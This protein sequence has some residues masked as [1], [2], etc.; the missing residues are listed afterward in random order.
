MKCIYS[1]VAAMLAILAGPPTTAGTSSFPVHVS[2]SSLPAQTKI[3]VSSFTMSA[4]LA[5][6]AVTLPSGVVNTFYTTTLTATGGTAPFTWSYTG[7]LPA[8]L[9]LNSSTGVISG[10]PTTAGTWS[11]TVKVTDSTTPTALTA[12]QGLSITINW[13]AQALSITTTSL[14]DGTAGAAYS[15]SVNATGGTGVYTWSIVS[16][17]TFPTCL[18]LSSTTGFISGSPVNTCLGSF[19][20]TVQVEDSASNTATQGLS[21]NINPGSPTFCESGNES[22]LNGHYA[23]DLSGYNSNGFNAV[24]GSMIADGAGHITGGEVDMNGI[25][26]SSSTNSPISASPASSYTVGSD[27]RGCATIATTSGATFT[28]RFELG[29]ISSGTATQGRIIEFDPATSSAFIASGQILRQTT[30]NFSGGLSG[31]YAFEQSGAGSHNRVVA[32]GVLSASSGSFSNGEVDMNVAGSLSHTTGI[33]GTYASADSNGR[34]TFTTTVPSASTSHGAGYMVSSSQFLFLTTDA[35]T[36]YGVLPGQMQ[37]QSGTFSNSSLSGNM[38]FYM[39]GLGPVG[40]F[41]I[42]DIGLLSANGTGS[43]TRT[44]YSGTL[45]TSLTCTY[46]IAS[47]GRTTITSS[48]QPPVFYLTAANTAFMLDTSVDVEIGQVLAQTVPGSG[49]TTASMAGTFFGGTTEIVNQ[50]AEAEGE[51]ATVSGSGSPNVSEI[52]DT[53]STAYQQADQVGTVALTVASTGT[54]APSAYPTYVI[55]IAIDTTHFLVVNSGSSYSTIGV[56]GPSTADTVAVSVSSPTTAQTV[57][58]NGGFFGITLNVTGTSGTA[59]TWTFN[60]LPSGSG[61]GTISG[62][63][64]SFTYAAPPRVPS[65]A[66]FSITATSDADLTKSAS[67]SVTISAGVGTQPLS[68]TTTSLPSSTGGAAYVQNVQTSGGTLPIIWSVTSGSLPP[69]LVLQGTPNGVGT[70]TG[71]PKASGTYTF[72]VAASDASIPTQY[73]SQQF[74]IVIN[75]VPLS[76]TTR[77]L[78][79]GTQG[80]AYSALVAVSGGTTPYTWSVTGGALPGWATLNAS[81]GAITGTPSSTATSNFTVTVTDSTLPTHQTVQQSLS[82]TISEFAPTCSGAPAGHESMLNGQ[83]AVLLQGF[84]LAFAASFHADGAGHVTGGDFDI[85]TG[86]ATDGTINASSYTVGPDPTGSGNLGCVA[87]PLSNGSTTIFRFSLGGLSSGV[88]SKARIIEFDDV[89]GEGRRGSGVLL[90]QDT[91]SFSLSHLQPHY[92]FGL[93]GWGSDGGHYASAGSF[94]VDTSGNISSGFEDFNSAG[95]APG[96]LTG[97][98]GTFNAISTT[99][100][101]ATMSLSIGGITTDQIIYMVNA[102]E[103]FIIGTDPVSSVPI[104]SGRAIVTASSFS[105]SSVS[106]NYIIHTTGLEPNCPALL[107]G[108]IFYYV[109]CNSTA[110]SLVNLDPASGTLSGTSY[111]YSMSPAIFEPSSFSGVSYAVDATSGRTTAGLGWTGAGVFYIATPTATTEPIS[112]FYVSTPDSRAHFGFVEYQPSA[113]YSTS[114]MAGNY[115]YGT[116]DSGDSAFPNEIG[117]VGVSSGGAVTG[118]E[119][120]SGDGGLGTS[121]PASTI[122]MGSNG[123][124]SRTFSDGCGGIVAITNGTRLFVMRDAGCY[125][126][127]S[128]IFLPAMINVYEFQP[129]PLV[130][131]SAPSLGFGNQ[132]L[133]TTSAPLTETVTNNGTTNL[134]IST[135]TIGGTNASDFA[136]STDICTSATVLPNSTCTVSV[137]FTPSAAGSRSA[138]LTFTDNAGDSPQMV[139]LSGTGA[140][141]VAGL[142]PFG[143]TF[144]SQ[145]VGIT[146]GLQ[147]V[148]LSNTGSAALT[149]TSITTGSDFAQTNNCAGSVAASGSCTINVT[150]TPTVPGPRKGMVTIN[151]NAAGSPHIVIVTGVGM[152]AGLAPSSL[153]F[154]SQ[155][156]GTSSSLQ[157]VTLS[158][159]G[160]GVMHIWQMAITGANASDFAKTTTCGSTLAAGTKCTISVTFTPSA[161]GTRSASLLVS[162]DGGGGPQAVALSGTGQ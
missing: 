136:K 85:N 148:T 77:A 42:V 53:A 18:S 51:M 95:T 91:T 119:Y 129:V 83:Y 21:I 130:G 81:S 147:P 142:S 97:G 80:T 1:C 54:I 45:Q 101:R 162:N 71:M 57:A 93:D 117:V 82:I 64:P 128:P 27:N 114:G 65:P 121:S 3:Q 160:S 89:T 115:F 141:P 78:P 16:G 111:Y 112:G 29:A 99:T 86:T 133:S 90:L 137:T 31:S 88:F 19:S 30:A 122:S 134:T 116:E 40:G 145:N 140:A 46:S 9:S 14:Q 120:D 150:F 41:A 105:Q 24:V 158:N 35:S 20:F 132:P 74:T 124:G 66:T 153:T 123:V 103:T 125:S 58:A 28:T 104:F 15:V 52:K 2:D 152:A 34:F 144:G 73:A 11:F 159:A 32:V 98:T 43:F 109:S 33:T 6:P 49:F 36:T 37:Q 155:N 44:D 26:A 138:S 161:G 146:S 157:M 62:S 60:G 76:I 107:S 135:V 69:G 63:Y 7:I 139:G 154:A 151:D 110:L 61:Y 94:T 5:F 70:I 48:A 143:L 39:T 10:T 96:K 156:V 55:G 38:V 17:G 59:V 87:L 131:L 102:D 84:Q 4:P 100:G 23:F 106:G 79:R 92:A 118:S 12:T 72:T 13:T 25:G 47:N 8:G 126:N 75:N 22:V 50:N 149:I 68:I 127:G 67:V 108:E 113:T 56:F